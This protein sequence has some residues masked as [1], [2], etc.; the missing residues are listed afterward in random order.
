MTSTEVAK[1]DMA[2][3]SAV[4]GTE[5]FVL[6]KKLFEVSWQ[7]FFPTVLAQDSGCRF[8]VCAYKHLGTKKAIVFETTAFIHNAV[9]QEYL[10]T[11][12]RVSPSTVTVA[13]AGRL[14]G[15]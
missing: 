4:A 9:Y 7:G 10:Y 6:R 13:V 8:K 1:T 14:S 5:L 2:N 15:R 3:L 12:I 11:M